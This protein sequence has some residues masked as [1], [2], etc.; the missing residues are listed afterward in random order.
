VPWAIIFKRA[1][2]T[3]PRHPAMLYES[4]SYLVLTGLLYL[5]YKKTEAKKRG[6][7]IGLMFFWIFTS[8]FII[9]FF[10]E[11]QVPF[12]N[13]LPLN[14]GQ[15]LSIPFIILGLVA[16]SGK[17]LEWLPWLDG[18]ARNPAKKKA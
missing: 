14:M 2:E 6:Q 9:E 3:V 1:G 15:I 11:N 4:A 5:L 13:D 12:E 16:F 10:K 8:R 18:T 17:L 7:M